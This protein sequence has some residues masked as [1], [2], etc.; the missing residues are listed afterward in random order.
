MT[1]DKQAQKSATVMV[2]DALLRELAVRVAIRR[3]SH[4]MDFAVSMA[5]ANQLIIAPSS[6]VG[7][8]LQNS[9]AQT[10]ASV[11]ERRMS[12]TCLLMH[13]FYP[14]SLHLNSETR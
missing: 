5:L 8:I 2:G 6:M 13:Q 14:I 12:L 3:A 10:A 9:C 11:V 4:V 1:L 7:L